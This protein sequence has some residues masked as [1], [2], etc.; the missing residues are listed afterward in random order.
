MVPAMTSPELDA[1]RAS[2]DTVNAEILD[3][4]NRRLRLVEEV[5][6]VKERQGRELF[7]PHR[8][9]EMFTRLLQQNDGPMTG[10]LVRKVFQEIFKLSLAHME[11]S[12]RGRLAVGRPE[13]EPGKP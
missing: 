13:G 3:L 12:A 2:I 8:E 6:E 1:L 7:N 10:E 9:S 4:L 5:K 11:A